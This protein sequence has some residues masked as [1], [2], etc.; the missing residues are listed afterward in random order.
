MLKKLCL[1]SFC[2]LP[3][4]LAVVA[5]TACLTACGEK[6]KPAAPA[7]PATETR[8]TAQPTAPTAPAATPAASQPTCFAS[9][10][11]SRSRS[12]FASP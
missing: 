8:T 2:S 1:Q 3:G 9:A 11:P 12:P 5:L 6:E 4:V 10:F 7:A